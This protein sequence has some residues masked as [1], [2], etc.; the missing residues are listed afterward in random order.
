MLLASRTQQAASAAQPSSGLHTAILTSLVLQ[1]Q[2]IEVQASLEV[3]GQAWGCSIEAG[4][5]SRQQR[6]QAISG[7]GADS[8]LMWQRQGPAVLWSLGPGMLFMT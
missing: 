8:V 4:V 3:T 2:G 6:L 1:R 5:A 7:I